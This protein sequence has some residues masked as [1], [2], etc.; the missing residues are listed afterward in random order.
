MVLREGL[1]QIPYMKMFHVRRGDGSVEIVIE[2][3][4]FT[5]KDLKINFQKLNRKKSSWGRSFNSWFCR[6]F[7]KLLISFLF[8]SHCRLFSGYLRSRRIQVIL[9]F[10]NDLK[11]FKIIGA[12]A[13]S[14]CRVLSSDVCIPFCLFLQPDETSRLSLP[15]STTITNTHVWNS[16]GQAGA[17]GERFT[18]PTEADVHHTWDPVA[19]VNQSHWLQDAEV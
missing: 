1:C 6:E 10:G 19:D 12:V 2:F 7:L 4:T 8:F 18:S 14:R 13:H 11:S 5:F 17:R 3:S 9:R 15:Q 16:S